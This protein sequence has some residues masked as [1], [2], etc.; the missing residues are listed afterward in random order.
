MS[1][2]KPYRNKEWLEEQYKSHSTG[3]IARMCGVSKSTIR[4][5]LKKHKIP[6]KNWLQSLLQGY[7]DFLG[8]SKRCDRCGKLLP[9]D[10]RYCC[11]C[12]KEVGRAE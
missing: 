11:Y 12:G 7:K 1:Q 5:W 2:D 10:A 4:Y 3:Y 6:R 9:P 8:F